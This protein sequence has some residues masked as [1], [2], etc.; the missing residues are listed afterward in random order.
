MIGPNDARQPTLEPRHAATFATRSA[1]PMDLPQTP[2]QARL[3]LHPEIA[4]YR[5]GRLQAGKLHEL[6][7]EECGNPEGRPA[8]LLHGGPGGG[9]NALMRRYHDPARYRIVLFDQ[10]GCGRST[11]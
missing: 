8:V 6:Y 11:R 1:S 5:T 7:F 3:T 9:S 2:V 4:P 10:R